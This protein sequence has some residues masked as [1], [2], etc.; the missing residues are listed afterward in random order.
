MHIGPRQALFL[1]MYI[2]NIYA[3][4]VILNIT[5]V[6][7][8]FRGSLRRTSAKLIPLHPHLKPLPSPTHSLLPI[9]VRSSGGS[10]CANCSAAARKKGAKQHVDDEF[11]HRP[12][13]SK[14]E[15]HN[16]CTSRYDTGRGEQQPHTCTS[17]QMLVI[18]TPCSLRAAKALF[19]T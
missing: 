5:L 17:P 19:L 18:R 6:Y 2:Y 4:V 1:H 3:P 13:N 10:F 14:S 11:T 15:K 9:F 7:P 8:S 12:I 16:N